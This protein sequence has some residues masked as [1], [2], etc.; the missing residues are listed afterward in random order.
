MTGWDD[1]RRG[2][3]E[4]MRGL[5]VAVRVVCARPGVV[6]SGLAPEESVVIEQES[7]P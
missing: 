4:A 7:R 1:E 2:I 3:V 6:L 5:S